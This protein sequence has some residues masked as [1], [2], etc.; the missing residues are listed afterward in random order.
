MV[1]ASLR[2][3]VSIKILLPNIYQSV[4]VCTVSCIAFRISLL[5]HEIKALTLIAEQAPH[6]M[7]VRYLFDLNITKT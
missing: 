1:I 5:D 6:I 4:C 3:A 2:M 7:Q